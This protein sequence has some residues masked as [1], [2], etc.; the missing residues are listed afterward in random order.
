MFSTTFRKGACIVAAV[1]YAAILAM[2]LTGCPKLATDMGNHVFVLA[3]LVFCAVEWR[4]RRD[5]LLLV[6]MGL[7]L[8]GDVLTGFDATFALAVAVLFASQ[9]VLSLII[10]RSDGGK[11]GLVLTGVLAAAG[12]GAIAGAGMLSPFYGFGVVYFM[13]FVANVVQAVAAGDALPLRFRVGAALYLLG[14]VCLIGNLLFAPAGAL[15]VILT[16]GTWMV[17]LPGVLALAL[18]PRECA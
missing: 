16:Y 6:F 12:L 18:S 3:C 17:Y 9:I 10:W 4:T 7:T 1:I 15:G 11:H 14:D 5:G 2:N 13:W 8:V